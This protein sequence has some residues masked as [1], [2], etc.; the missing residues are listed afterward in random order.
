MVINMLR[1]KIT[2]NKSM[3]FILIALTECI[4]MSFIVRY[5]NFESALLTML[6]MIYASLESK[7]D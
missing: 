7:G 3:K 1:R 6:I 4:V 5:C 2:M